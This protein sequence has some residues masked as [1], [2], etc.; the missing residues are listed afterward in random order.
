[1]SDRT[2]VFHQNSSLNGSRREGQ[3]VVI[4]IRAASANTAVAGTGDCDS[5]IGGD[6]RYI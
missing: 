1:M 6:R 5:S 4:I 3:A 2:L